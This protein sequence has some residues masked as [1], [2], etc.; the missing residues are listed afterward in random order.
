MGTW[1][2]LAFDNDGAG[3]WAFGLDDVDDLSLVEATFGELEGVE[4]DYLDAGV[5]CDA[6]AACE[7]LARLR[8]KVGYTN[9]FTE[10]VDR[11]VAAHQIVPP[12]SLLARAAA[13]IDRILGE[14]S[15]LGE[16]WG[17]GDGAEWRAAVAALRD[18]VID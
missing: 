5:A 7:V 13:A 17:E 15:E 10:P 16:L 9:A 6:L 1:G 8:G 4:G 12:A 2:A 14:N 11:W 3:D 18:R